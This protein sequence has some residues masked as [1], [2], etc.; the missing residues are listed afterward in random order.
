MGKRLW[1]VLAMFVFGLAVWHLPGASARAD[2]EQADVNVDHAAGQNDPRQAVALLDE[3][4]DRCPSFRAWYVKGSAHSML[5][6][7]D[8]ALAAFQQARHAS[9]AVPDQVFEAM[10][11]IALMKHHLGYACEASRE[12][13]LLRAPYES[14]EPLPGWL[15][16]PYQAHER[17][18]AEKPMGADEIAC[19]L[20]MTK[21]FRTF[22]ICPHLNI[23]IPFAYDRADIDDQN[24]SQVQKLGEA[25]RR[26]WGEEE[27]QGYRLVGHTDSRGSAHYNQ[28]LSERRAKS[29]LAFI[30]GRHPDLKEILW[31]SGDGENRLLDTEDTES[32][33]ALNRRVEVQVLCD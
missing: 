4:V 8:E 25:L 14:D 10:S 6:Q 31:A 19:A 18:L 22:N 2:C 1:L 33:H 12:F 5:R 11:Y 26:V 16:V 24:R 13:R 30:Q 28:N 29:V 15:H 9:N 21:E 20:Q 23:R 3:I 17:L 32:A 27:V 7:W